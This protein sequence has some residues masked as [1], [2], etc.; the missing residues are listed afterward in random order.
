[1]DTAGNSVQPGEVGRLRYRGPGVSRLM[2][3]ADGV[4]TS[5]EGA[6]LEPGD[7]ARL[8]PSGHVQ[9]AGRAKDMIIRGGVNIYPAEIEAALRNHPAIAELCVFGVADTR[10]GEKIIAAIIPKAGQ[11]ID[12]EAV[13]DFARSRLAEYK[14]PD[15]IVFVSELPRNSSG[16]VIREALKEL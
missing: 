1:M 12:A 10:L 5:N 16:K 11:F 4:L 13:Q 3:S 2:V 6:W 9:L 14:T 15:R 7:L 8:L